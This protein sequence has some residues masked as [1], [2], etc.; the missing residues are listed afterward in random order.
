MFLGWTSIRHGHPVNSSA[1]RFIYHLDRLCRDGAVFDSI[2]AK[3]DTPCM[4]ALSKAPLATHLDLNATRLQDK[5]FNN[6]HH[7]INFY[8][9]VFLTQV[10]L[11]AVE[12][13]SMP[14]NVRSSVTSDERKDVRWTGG[15]NNACECRAI[16][17]NGAEF[18]LQIESVIDEWREK[19]KKKNC[20]SVTK[21]RPSSS[22]GV[23][24]ACDTG[25]GSTGYDR[26]DVGREER[27][28]VVCRKRK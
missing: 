6:W 10:R 26:R 3:I 14:E 20:L 15:L 8:D 23:A 19:D 4:I 21:A 28:F 7:R 13:V 11:K 2:K 16:P 27:S 25:A 5:M 22:M 1:H 24:C 12:G 9:E 17:R 18:N